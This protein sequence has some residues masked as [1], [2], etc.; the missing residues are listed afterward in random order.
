MTALIP[1]EDTW[2]AHDV[3]S[4]STG[5][6][7]FSFQYF[8]KTDL[9]VTVDNV[10]LSQS[11]WS[12][13]LGSAVDAGGY[14]GGSFSLV[15]AVAN[16][17]VVIARKTVVDRDANLSPS[18]LTY[19]NIN[20][21]LNKHVYTL[22]EL[23][24]DIARALL[25]NYGTSGAVV[26][27]ANV[28]AVAAIADEVA[29]VAGIDAEVLILAGLSAEITAIAALGVGDLEAIAAGLAAKVDIAGG[30]ASTTV[31]TST[32]SSTARTLA[33]R[34]AEDVNVLDFGAVGDG[35]TEDTAAIVAAA[36]VA[37]AS[38]KALQFPRTSNGTY[39][40]DFLNFASAIRIRLDD[41]VTLKLK[42]SATEASDELCVVKFNASNSSLKGGTID[43][44]RDNQGKAAFNT[45]GGTDAPKYYNAV[46]AI[47]TSG[48]HI[49]DVEIETKIINSADY[50]LYMR[51]CDD[52][53][54]NV[55]VEDSGAGVL[56]RDS[57]R[58]QFIRAICF[59]LDNDGWK[60]Y[61]HGIDMFF[62][63]EPIGGNLAVF[64][65]RGTG[66]VAG[67]TSLSDWISGITL[68][69]VTNPH[70]SGLFWSQY[71]DRATLLTASSYTK[72][73][74]FSMLDVQGGSIS[75]VV[76][77]NFSSCG[78][79][80]GGV[81]SCRLT[82]I[83]LD[84]A[85]MKSSLFTS[86]FAE[87]IHLIDQGYTDQFASRSMQPV[88]DVSLVNVDA[89]RCL[90]PG[91][92]VYC[93]AYVDF[94]GLTSH[95]N[96]DGIILQSNPVNASFPIDTKVTRCIRLIGGD[97]HYNE[98]YGALDNGG[99]DLHL[100]GTKLNNN[101]QSRTT[102]TAG[103]LRS[104]GTFAGPSYGY[105][106]EDGGPTTAR[107]RT[108]LL[109]CQTQDD[110]S[111]TTGKAS[112]VSTAP[113]KIWVWRPELYHVGQTVTL[114]GCGAAAADLTTQILDINQ[115]ELTVGD[116]LSTF[117]SASGTGTISTSGTTITGS[118]TDFL[119]ELQ[120]VAYITANSETR[121]VIAATTS[122]AATLETAFSTN[123]SGEAFT[124]T[125]FAAQQIQSQDYGIGT[126]NSTRDA[127]LCA[128]GHDFGPGNKTGNTSLASA[129]AIRHIG[130]DP[131]FLAS[132]DWESNSGSPALG[133]S[134]GGRRTVWLLDGAGA[135]EVLQAE[136]YTPFAGKW[137]PTIIWHNAG[138]GSGD[139][140]L[141][142]DW[143]SR[144]AGETL[145][146]AGT[147]IVVTPTAG[148]QDIPV[149]T[150]FG[151]EITSQTGELLYLRII[152]TSGDASDTLANDI[153]IVGVILDPVTA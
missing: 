89:T 19:Q 77:R 138:A 151:S 130:G 100:I 123:L 9:E 101:G 106:G 21:L 140:H 108:R 16:A 67:G 28:D 43:F 50:G 60:V 30:N 74:A 8:A 115:D 139:V 51:Y 52:A 109:H 81:E 99:D 120:G 4:S 32:G 129:G 18:Q 34:F 80:L 150:A 40:T 75:D 135:T 124:I 68:V 72:S 148:A 114:A 2:S 78:L 25:A 46:H 63:D 96:R 141:T 116:A 61:P 58:P 20:A 27:S 85:Y 132:A 6:F 128:D 95:G 112:A 31:V 82:S 59:D 41:G 145:N 7:N 38:G 39:I 91:A 65:Q 142:L 11:A 144:G 92:I 10:A 86:E 29:L 98:R 5:P 71:D 127:T 149:H 53:V 49:T 14:D 107:N 134:G 66:T 147:G 97:L 35:T 118:G 69:G 137:Q 23:R 111:V 45:A 136:V 104:T 153:G 84:S 47:G 152:R 83:D 113:T 44:N 103:T 117:P 22:Q 48:A 105:R 56:V 94:I 33:A 131:I 64:N 121:K 70:L 3:V 93:A 88:R 36:V 24:R 102:A 146:T 125:S 54:I 13:T 87:G 62:V 79:E 17:R 1:D 76:G 133:T 15:T 57:S 12:L 42:N 73:L 119:N 122:T 37:A 26:D 143:V 110:Q 55:Q 90:G 126:G